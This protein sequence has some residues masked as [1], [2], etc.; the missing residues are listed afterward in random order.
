[1]ALLPRYLEF[2]LG[3]RPKIV[4]CLS[5]LRRYP[6]LAGEM[7][8]RVQFLLERLPR[9]GEAADLSA[10]VEEMIEGGEGRTARNESVAGQGD[11][12]TNPAMR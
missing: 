1:M 5:L 7:A 6:P 10:A 11:L 9:L 3:G 2:V 8:E 12:R 4:R